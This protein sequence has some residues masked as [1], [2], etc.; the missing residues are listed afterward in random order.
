MRES[1]VRQFEGLPCN[2]VEDTRKRKKDR[3]SK[4]KVKIREEKQEVKKK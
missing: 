1:C 4:V 3:T 2:Q